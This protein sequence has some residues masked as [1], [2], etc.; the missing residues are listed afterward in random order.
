ML[1]EEQSTFM[2]DI[3]TLACGSSLDIGT[4]VVA[5]VIA[6]HPVGFDGRAMKV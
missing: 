6:E 4:H 3:G 1:I 5:H 2:I